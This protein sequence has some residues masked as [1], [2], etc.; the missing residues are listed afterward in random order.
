MSDDIDT[1]ILN[2]D[3]NKLTLY[4]I[5]KINSVGNITSILNDKVKSIKKNELSCKEPFNESYWYLFYIFWENLIQ[6]KINESKNFKSYLLIHLINLG[7]Y[8]LRSGKKMEDITEELFQGFV[9]KDID[10]T[11][12]HIL[13]Y[14]PNT[15]PRECTK[16]QNSINELSRYDKEIHA[17]VEDKKIGKV[18]DLFDSLLKLQLKALMKKTEESSPEL[19]NFIDIIS[20]KINAVNSILTYPKQEIKNQSGG[21]SL[22]QNE[23]YFYKYLK[24]KSKYINLKNNSIYY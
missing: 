17:Y 2:M 1:I 23:I 21:Q 7:N 4:Q 18:D 15:D 11:I 12:N 10:K 19:N 3:K 14:K 16:L 8:T 24:Y 5:E 20:K 9:E 22:P 13:N 6:L